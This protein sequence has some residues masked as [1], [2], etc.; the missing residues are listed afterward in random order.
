MQWT[1][2]LALAALALELVPIKFFPLITHS[3][4]LLQLEVE[5][6]KLNTA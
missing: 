3:T 4:L 6:F 1:A 2:L 5:V